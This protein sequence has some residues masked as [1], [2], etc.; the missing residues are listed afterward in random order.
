M[1]ETIKNKITAGLNESQIR[2]VTFGDG[3]LLVVAGAGS[4]KTRVIT[5][6]VAYM[7][8][9]GVPPGRILGITFTNKAASEM[10]RRVDEMVGAGVTIKT[11]HAFCAMLLRRRI[12]HLGYDPSFTIYDRS[13]SL[14]VVRRLC[15]ALN[16]DPQYYKPGDLLDT[17]S[18]YKDRLES[19]Q[20]AAGKAASD[21]DEQAARIYAAYEEKLAENNAL[22][23][24]DL[25]LKTVQ[26]FR[27][28]PDVLA[29]SQDYCRHLMVDEYQDT[30]L[31]QHVIARALQGKHRNI[32]AVGDP[33]Q[34]IYTWR[35]ARMANIMEFEK[36]F[37]GASVIS[38]ERNYRSTA[39]ILRAAS[40][41]IKFNEL[42]YEKNL[43]TKAGEG[44]PVV[45]AGHY[46]APEEASWVAEKIRELTDKNGAGPSVGVLYRTKYQSGEFERVF[47][48]EDIPY[49]VVDTTGFFDRKAI[50]DIAAY[51]H[52]IVNP[53]D[54][55]ALRRIINVPTRGIG[56]VTLDRIGHAANQADIPLLDAVM[57]T[58]ITGK[59][60]SRAAGALAGFAALYSE[61]S[62]YSRN[63][64]N[65]RD[66]VEAVIER[67]GYLASISGDE[68]EETEELLAYFKGFAEQHQNQNPD[69]GLTGFMEQSV[70]ASDVDGWR[71]DTDSVSLLTLHS[72]KGLEFDVVFLTGVENYILPH[73]RAV[74]ERDPGGDG[75]EGLE[76]ERRLFHVG[77]TRA[78]KLLF[79]TYASERMIK[80]RFEPTGP[81]RFLTE[82]PHEG[83]FWEGL[84]DSGSRRFGGRVKKR[85][86]R[87]DSGKTGGKRAR[88]KKT[89]KSSHI[90]PGDIE[91]GGKIEHPQYGEG[92]VISVNNIGKKKQVK[93]DF[94]S[95]E[96][97]LTILQ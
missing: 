30:N 10:A 34:M 95:Y 35:G 64:E 22:D 72:A 39:N 80:G 61:L 86:M 81:S 55:I 51:L 79:L 26:L 18:S 8:Q 54:E 23:F 11:F 53:R 47:A 12:H 31:A 70:L 32:T 4:G 77:M 28:Y 40:H 49:Q 48:K 75:G 71:P 76:E 66:V 74:E 2:A 92:T 1:P 97:P 46:G 17:I 42:R 27:E 33:D 36:E 85:K 25:L 6:R 68:K 69:A 52:L 62:E 59:L 60:S 87:P 21:W 15:K 14:R 3:P 84:V 43:Y 78:R 57:D 50:K 45:V 41:A 38:L 96:E 9:R 20:E 16:L 29:R 13:D 83:V 65:V 19:P 44:R 67:T 63:A 82:L 94:D 93:V 7:V 5:H 91:P 56:A 89:P 90:A 88:V 58:K 24:D 73:L 37:P